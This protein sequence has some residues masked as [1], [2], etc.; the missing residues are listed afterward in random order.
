VALLSLLAKRTSRIRTVRK[1]R[2]IRP[3]TNKGR[4]PETFSG[5]RVFRFLGRPPH[6]EYIDDIAFL[7]RN[8]LYRNPSPGVDDGVPV[9][10]IY[11]ERFVFFN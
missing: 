6:D 1:V 8:I 3:K 4:R 7:K 10:H 11:N 2:P 5:A 9:L